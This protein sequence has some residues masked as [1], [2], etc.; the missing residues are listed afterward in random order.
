MAPLSSEEIRE[1]A[2]EL[3]ARRGDS[4]VTFAEWEAIGHEDAGRWDEARLWRMI[5]GTA[6]GMIDD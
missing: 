3:V 6:L 1:K 2:R 5:A 4:A